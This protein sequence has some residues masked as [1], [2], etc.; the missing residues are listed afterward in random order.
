[1]EITWLGESA[2]LLKGRE[3]KVLVDPSYPAPGAPAASSSE[4]VISARGGENQL[5]PER[6]PQVVA[7]P[8]EYE[9]RGVSVRGVET[10]AGTAFVAE[11]DEVAVCD[12]GELPGALDAEVIDALG[13][14]DV[15]AVSL[16]QGSA[17]RALEVANLISQLQPAVVVPVGF[18]L[19]SDGSLGELSP[20]AQ[21]MGL[22][23]V[24]PQAKL[25]LTGSAGVSDETRVVVL[26]ARR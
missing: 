17:A 12:F 1:M 18:Q 8:G 23:Q 22:T 2:L 4:I 11:V 15:L 6:G 21:E 26:E 20:F 9:L 10:G 7:R 16:Q 25:S 14:I 5:R 13:S 3:T 24:N 19:S